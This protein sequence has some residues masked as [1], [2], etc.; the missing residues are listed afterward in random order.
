MAIEIQPRDLKI[1]RH[2]FAHRVLTY[3][4]IS[5]RF[6]PKNYETVARNRIGK[7]VQHGY[8]RS[9]GAEKKKRLV[10]CLS[11]A[12]KS[13]PL[14]SKKWGFE[15]DSPHFRSESV[16]HDFRLVE[17][18]LKFEGLQSFVRFLPENLLQSSSVLAS[19]S[20]FR[21]AV[22]LQSDGVLILKGNDGGEILYAVE[23][24][25]SKKAPDRY[26]RKLE[27]YY[28]AGGLDGVLYICGN[29]E[30]TTAVAQADR[31]ARTGNESI[32]FLAGESSVLKSET[33]IIFKNVDHGGIGLELTPNQGVSRSTDLPQFCFSGTTEAV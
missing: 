19:D 32:V 8:F 21:D 26:V 4:Q 7:L 10:R 31:K 17:V 23:F 5:R 2:V 9:F 28:Q 15:V 6:F 1:M 29:Q 22:N 20:I 27:G 3:D 18:A 11:L 14:I 12:E 25:I 24:E 13:W 30:I 33:K 16:E